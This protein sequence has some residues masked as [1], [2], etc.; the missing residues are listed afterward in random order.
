ME[1]LR[2]DFGHVEDAELRVVHDHFGR[3]LGLG[4]Q[5]EDDFDAVNPVRFDRLFDQ[6]GRRDQ[7]HRADRN[8]FA[9]TGIDLAAFAAR[10][11]RAELEQ[12]AAEHRVAGDHILADRG[13]HE[14]RRRPD[15]HS[16]GRHVIGVDD[17]ADAAEVIDMA[18]S[19]DD[20]DHGLL[21]DVLA[22]EVKGGLGDLGRNQRIDH[23]ETA[24]A[25]DD[26]H[27]GYVEAA[28]LMDAIGH[29][30]ETVGHVH[31]RMTPEPGMNGVGR[32]L[33]PEELIAGESPHQ[34]TVS[35]NYQLIAQGLDEAAPSVIERP[36]ISQRHVSER[37][38]VG[39][40]R[41]LSRVLHRQILFNLR[42]CR[43]GRFRFCWRV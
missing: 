25:L 8:A 1:V 32:L 14:T 7:R 20:R 43:S 9:E 38:T 10:Q 41:S 18:V 24:V 17:S 39:R 11:H 13:G 19:I 2:G 3:R 21:R 31:S 16:A 15:C 29:L 26:R 6:V 28:Q 5:L 34:P 35:A 40:P 37:R 12:R 23:D 22:V 33:G 36:L 4:S 30:V 27:V 42:R